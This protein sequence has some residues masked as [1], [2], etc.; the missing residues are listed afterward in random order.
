MVFDDS[1]GKFGGVET[2][3]LCMYVC[4]CVCV[5]VGGWAVPEVSFDLCLEDDGTK[6]GSS[7]FSG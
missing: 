7:L 3:R 4:E 1:K 2:E 5:R 6:I